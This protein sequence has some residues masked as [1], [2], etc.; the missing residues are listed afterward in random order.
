[1]LLG[2]AVTEA[3][4]IDVDVTVDNVYAIYTGTQTAALASVGYNNDWTT[5]E[6]Y[7]FNLLNNQPSSPTSRMTG[8]TKGSWRSSPT[9]RVVIASMPAIRNGR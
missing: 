7:H 2:A 5:T 1:M 3:D 8:A 6:H 4:L 9:R